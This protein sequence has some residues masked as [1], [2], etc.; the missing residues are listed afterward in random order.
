[1]RA[2][3]INKEYFKDIL[4]KEDSKKLYDFFMDM[5][6]IDKNGKLSIRFF[7]FYQNYFIFLPKNLENKREDIFKAISKLGYTDRDF[8]QSKADFKKAPKGFKD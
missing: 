7:M 8:M 5:K 6:Y 1:M 2:F 3:Y 4:G